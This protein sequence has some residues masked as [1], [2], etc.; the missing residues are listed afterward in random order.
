MIPLIWLVAGVVLVL[1]EILTGT[2]VLLMLG[3]AAL[4]AA[5]AS[6]LGAPPG[7]DLAVFAVVSVAGVVLARPI[8]SRRLQAP[9]TD[10]STGTRGL[11]GSIG[12]VL[13]AVTHD[14]PGTVRLGGAVWTARALGEDVLGVGDQ[15]VVVQITGATAVVAPRQVPGR[16][17]ESGVG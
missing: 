10:L 3:V 14:E 13:E 15:V 1:A 8:L 9:D 4:V 2:L 6:A 12:E 7:V 17:G 5:G 16:V 11:L